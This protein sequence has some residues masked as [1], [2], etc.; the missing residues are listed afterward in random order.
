M[1]NFVKRMFLYAL[2]II[3]AVGKLCVQTHNF[4]KRMFLYALQI[5]TAV[6]KLCVQTH[7][8]VKRMFLYALQIITAVGKLCVQTHNFVKR[9]F[10]YA[11]QLFALI[12]S[13]IILGVNRQFSSRL[14]LFCIRTKWHHFWGC[15]T[16]VSQALKLNSMNKI[17]RFGTEIT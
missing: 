15:L 1:H 7:N 12:I 17:H 5:I 2:Q 14:C 3:T 9:M 10:L 4:V 6:G 13:Q 11:L 16:N 8:F